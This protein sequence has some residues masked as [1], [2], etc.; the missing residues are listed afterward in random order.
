MTIESGGKMLCK[1][2]NTVE[3]EGELCHEKR[4]PGHDLGDY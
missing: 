2:E 3:L 1:N 4:S